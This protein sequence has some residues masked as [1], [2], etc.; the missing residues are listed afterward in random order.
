[1]LLSTTKVALFPGPVRKIGTGPGN[2]ATMKACSRGFSCCTLARKAFQRLG[3]HCICIQIIM[4]PKSCSHIIPEGDTYVA[5]SSKC[6]ETQRSINSACLVHICV[7]TI[8][9]LD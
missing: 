7:H 1:M 2:E 5:E 3:F 9:S 8:T 6:Q 4:V